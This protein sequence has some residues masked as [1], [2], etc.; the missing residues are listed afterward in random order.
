[1]SILAAIFGFAR[2]ILRRRATV[3]LENLALRSR[4]RTPT[5]N[6]SSDRS[7]GNAPTT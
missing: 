6:E 1:M 2:A 3:A 5:P 7:D 4:G